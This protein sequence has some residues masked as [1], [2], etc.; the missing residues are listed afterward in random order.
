MLPSVGEHRLH[1]QALTTWKHWAEGH[2]VPDRTLH[3]AFAVLAHRPGPEQQLAAAL[4]HD[5]GNTTVDRGRVAAHHEPTP[6]PVAR[7]DLG[8]EL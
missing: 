8:I 7:P 4:R 5:L 1:V 3:T 6:M 2:D